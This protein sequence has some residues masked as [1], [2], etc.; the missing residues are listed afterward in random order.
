ML[1]EMPLCFG[2]FSNTEMLVDGIRYEDGSAFA[3][4]D[5]ADVF[6]GGYLSSRCVSGFFNLFFCRGR[7]GLLG[8]G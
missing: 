5:L 3:F 2:G 4:F 1:E 7:K 8:K 6:F